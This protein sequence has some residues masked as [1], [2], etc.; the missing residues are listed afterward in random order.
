[1]DVRHIPYC[2]V[3]RYSD[4]QVSKLQQD[5]KT[6]EFLQQILIES[7]DVGVSVSV[8]WCSPYSECSRI[9]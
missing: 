7:E 2:D 3:L 4:E 9:S 8:P 6:T 5:R 1:M